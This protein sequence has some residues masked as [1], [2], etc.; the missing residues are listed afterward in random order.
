M[1]MTPSPACYVLICSFE[2]CFLHA[3]LDQGGVPTIGWGHIAGVHMGDTCTQQQADL[4]LEEEI[5]EYAYYVNQTVDVYH[6][7]Q[8]E[9][10]ALV[11]FTYNCGPGNFRSLT[12]K[13]QRTKQQ[14]IDAFP[15]FNKVKQGNVRIVSNG[16]VRR[17]REELNLFLTGTLSQQVIDNAPPET[18][19][20][21]EYQT[22]AT[23]GEGYFYPQKPVYYRFSKS[24]LIYYL[25]PW[26]KL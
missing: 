10:D 2:H 3:Y 25:K 8:Y 26:W 17:R 12:N 19:H 22:G 6:W 9:F 20:K 4:W 24:P 23:G 21:G 13:N 15:S 11:S 7:T 1:T 14:I 18:P 5:A 16:L